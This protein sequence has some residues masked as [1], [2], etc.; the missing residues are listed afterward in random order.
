[1][2]SGE[3]DIQKPNEI[4]FSSPFFPIWSFLGKGEPISQPSTEI[5]LISSNY[6][7]ETVSKETYFKLS[8]IASITTLKAENFKIRVK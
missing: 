1:M 4:I 2:D 5:S 7:F 6:K 8:K 3:N